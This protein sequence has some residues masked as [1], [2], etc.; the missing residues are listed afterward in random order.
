MIQSR[1]QIHRSRFLPA[2]SF[3]VLALATQ[4]LLA[5]QVQ[6][7]GETTSLVGVLAATPTASTKAEKPKGTRFTSSLVVKTSSGSNWTEAKAEI[8]GNTAR[9]Q[10]GGAA[11]PSGSIAGHSK[12]YANA[13][14]RKGSPGMRFTFRSTT[15]QTGRMVVVMKPT[16]N[17]TGWGNLI[18]AKTQVQVG[19]HAP[20]T[21]DL[22]FGLTITREFAATIDPAGMPVD[23]SIEAEAYGA[24]QLTYGMEVSVTFV[25]GHRVTSWGENCSDL[26]TSFPKAQEIRF[27]FQ[28]ALPLAPTFLL[29]GDRKIQAPIGFPSCDLLV[30]PVLVLFGPRTDAQARATVSMP[31]PNANLGVLAQGAIYDPFFNIFQMSNGAE[32]QLQKR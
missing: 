9:F 19:T 6:I 3:A 4:G 29:F 28:G 32:I 12:G 17:F 11:A 21:A 22:F 1:T 15:A 14:T 25:P 7:Q 8:T 26:H 2:S 30:N 16:A 23:I 10:I 20:T 5:Q 13:A 18:T 31:I 27:H 24:T